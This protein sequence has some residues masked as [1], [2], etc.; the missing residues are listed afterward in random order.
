MN[1]NTKYHWQW[2][3]CDG[4]DVYNNNSES[5][6]KKIHPNQKAVY[7]MR[8]DG[9][10][11][12]LFDRRWY[13]EDEARLIVDE[14]NDQVN[15][16]LKEMEEVANLQ[17]ATVKFLEEQGLKNKDESLLVVAKK[18]VAV[19]NNIEAYMESPAPPK[20]CPPAPP[21]P[22]PPAPEVDKR[23]EAI[24]SLMEIHLKNVLATSGSL[25]NLL[26]VM[27]GR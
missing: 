5:G 12:P 2:R 6:R 7:I 10:G 16:L 8:G 21:K 25:N 23:K 4:N 19:V 26:T 20:P 15:A 14:H 11:V 22:C 27:S 17:E 13:Y 9:Q 3:T 1:D 18:M 24:N